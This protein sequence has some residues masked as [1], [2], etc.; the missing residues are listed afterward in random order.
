MRLKSLK[1]T[2]TFLL[3]NVMSACKSFVKVEERNP[4]WATSALQSYN[5]FAKK[6][7]IMMFS[8]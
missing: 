6:W 5:H 2:N 1:I 3:F 8:R 4:L 7:V